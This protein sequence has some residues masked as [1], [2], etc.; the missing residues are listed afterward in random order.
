MVALRFRT[1][2]LLALLLVLPT[3]P[4][5]AL[6]AE[7]LLELLVEE[8]VIT[9]EKAQRLKQK[10]LKREQAR[11]AQEQTQRAQELERVKQE[12]KAEAKAEAIQEI[13]AAAKEAAP[14]PKLDYG[15]KGGFYVQTPDEKFRTRMRIGLQTRFVNLSRDK[16]VIPNNESTSYFRL[17]RA[18]LYLDG[19]LFSKDLKYY[20]QLQMEPQS[21]VN[22]H[23]AQIWYA[24]WKFFQPWVGRGKIPYLLEEWQS[25]FKNNFID[26]SIF[27]GES[28]E[29]WPGGNARLRSAADFGNQLFNQGGFTLGRSQG[30]MVKGD[31][32][33]W[34]P[35]TVRYWAGIWNGAETRGLTSNRDAEF[36][37]S[38]RLLFAPLPNGGPDDDEL[39]TRGDYAFRKGWPMFYVM[40]A[41]FTNRD[42]NTANRPG[43]TVAET[44]DTSNH[45]Y[46]LAASFKWYGFSLQAEWARETF[47][48]FRPDT[49][50]AGQLGQGRRTAHREGFYV[51]A[52][53]FL[54]PKRLE[55]VLRYAYVNRVK[56]PDGPYTWSYLATNASQ[57]DFLVPVGKDGAI[58][59]AREGIC[60]EITAGL[61]FYVHGP[62]HKY[63]VDYS[64]LIR[65]FYGAP[66]QH[67]NRFRL[68]GVWRF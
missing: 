10:A 39:T 40:A 61:N 23:D 3:C 46:D 42:R 18:R 7:D 22:L 50:I 55:A 6:S 12:A 59:D 33:L 14:A 25:S 62:S 28:D 21:A 44:F 2:A 35:R 5:Y 52:G 68:Q 48:E 60:R 67:D 51:A 56:D 9:P 66:N 37:Y 31:L 34:A 47:T 45:G 8:K 26:K 30:V 63:M 32:D 36:L 27:Q 17:R 43:T 49:F 1:L 58:V 13:K 41:A 16:E 4:V 24:R 54:W 53:Q 65:Q 20:L 38:G 11:Q 64:R 29:N 19:N 15:Y 57:T